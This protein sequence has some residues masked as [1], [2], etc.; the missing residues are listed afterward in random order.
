MTNKSSKSWADWFGRSEDDS[1]TF[2]NR[3]NKGINW[4]SGY[5]NFSDFLLNDNSNP[6]EA[7]RLVG[8]MLQVLGIEKNEKYTSSLEQAVSLQTSQQKAVILLPGEF[9]ER[10]KKT[11]EGEKLTAA[12]KSD[13]F[14]GGAV[15]NA[16]TNVY[17]NN[18]Q[19]MSLFEKRLTLRTESKTKGN[20]SGKY[21]ALEKLRD[22]FS[23]AIHDERTD[24]KVAEQ[25]PGYSNFIQ[26]YKDIKFKTQY[27]PQEFETPYEEFTDL[28]MRTIQHPGTL[29]PELLEK[30]E[31][32]LREVQKIM[33]THGGIPQTFKG[34]DQ[35]GEELAQYIYRMIVEPPDPSGGGG[36]GSGEGGGES[37]SSSEGSS[38]G[39]GGTPPPPTP[40]EIAEAL[41]KLE[42][43]IEKNGASM[44]S[45]NDGDDES[46]AMQTVLDELA[47]MG[48]Y[49][50]MDH[51]EKI[52][53]KQ[54]KG[55]RREYERLRDS[56]DMAKASVIGT[57][58]R[59]K[60]RDY[61]FSIKSTRSG[62]LDTNKLVEAR[63]K[64]PT[65]YERI[66]Q[67]KTDKLSV[68]ILIDES[69]SMSGA[70]IRKAQEAAI[71]L[72][73]ALKSQ[74]DINLFIYGHT[75]D[76]HDRGETNIQVYREPGIHA[77]Y[78]L[79]AVSAKSNNRDGTAI[80]A[81]AKRVRKHTQDPVVFIVISDG[82]PAASGYRSFDHGCEHTAK[83]V[84]RTEALGMQVIQIAIESMDSGKMFRNFIHLTDMST[85]PMEFTAFLKR[86]MNEMIKE[87]VT[88]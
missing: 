44:V 9:L 18:R 37:D 62:R 88:C 32:E 71:F 6:R 53:I 84:K 5:N 57:L 58:L 70:K 2:R 82:Y 50:E 78:S 83:H 85:F 4:E 72:N 54:P 36:G 73:E 8:N 41:K 75:A 10:G 51:P 59:R 35:L 24:R 74:P 20:P 56:L 26:K 21:G 66:G 27:E 48:M 19:A 86:K 34:C 45:D 68:C 76:H 7:A 14:L 38:S 39:G 79:S 3:T 25:F 80:F 11:A 77:P 67:V 30:Y 17:N 55:D 28:L 29:E 13:A 16:A 65:V 40:Q 46:R 81:C 31:R 15:R 12:E 33:D 69:G 22:M 87:H 42:E 49:D 1:Y 63:M 52:L 60:A 61:K 64:V 23:L 43:L 47:G